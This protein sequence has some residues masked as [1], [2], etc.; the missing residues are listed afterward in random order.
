MLETPEKN[1]NTK[2]WHTIHIDLKFTMTEKHSMKDS[3]NVFCTVCRLAE[4]HFDQK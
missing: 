3:P 4:F 1:F 2:D